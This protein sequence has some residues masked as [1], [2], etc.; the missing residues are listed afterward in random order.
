[1]TKR[2]FQ[3][4]DDHF[5]IFG[6]RGTGKSTWISENLPNAYIINLL[7]DTTYREHLMRP[8]YITS[9][10]RFKI[11]KNILFGLPRSKAF[12]VI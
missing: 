9:I 3:A 10:N 2:F 5:F 11:F 6:P 7:D 8:N 4:P 12:I 1:M